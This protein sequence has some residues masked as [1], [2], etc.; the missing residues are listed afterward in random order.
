L[1]SFD[2]T[3]FDAMRY[4]VE[5]GDAVYVVDIIAL[6]IRCCSKAARIF[7]KMRDA[8]T[9]HTAVALA[10]LIPSGQYVRLSATKQFGKKVDALRNI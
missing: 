2:A 8:E 9:A 10:N 4:I 7:I 1:F 5:G 3:S 6:I